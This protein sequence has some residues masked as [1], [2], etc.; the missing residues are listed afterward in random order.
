MKTFGPLL[1]LPSNKLGENKSV[2]SFKPLEIIEVDSLVKI[3][4]PTGS[5]PAQLFVYI[6][7]I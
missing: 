7:K 1:L 3:N 5:P 6:R 4:V 2:Q